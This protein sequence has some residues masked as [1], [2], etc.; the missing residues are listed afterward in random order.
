MD[1]R[2]EIIEGFKKSNEYRRLPKRVERQ[3]NLK[4]NQYKNDDFGIEI[5]YNLIKNKLL[6]SGIKSVVD[7][8]GKSGFFSIQMLDEN[9]ISRACVYDVSSNALKFG[10][11]I[12]KYLGLENEINFIEKKLSIDNINNIPNADVVLCLNLIH[13]AGVFFDIDLVGERG[14]AEYA[15]DF[16]KILRKK[17]RIAA[18][19]VGFKGK[20][21]V[22]WLIP[23]RLRP[24][25]FNKIANKAGWKVVYDANV[26]DLSL[27]GEK[28]ACGRRTKKTPYILSLEIIY[29]FMG[30]NIVN[31]ISK[32]IEKLNPKKIDNEKLSKYHIFILK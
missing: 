32:T 5:R 10:N 15:V 4:T 6:N 26:G 21:P 29:R 22:N 11:K 13:H 16:L 3:L 14:W 27:F 18:V 2:D 12:A 25:Y 30:Y 31:K 23:N 20:K 1:L 9:I 19:S 8:G 7:L 17:Y 24:V 28:I